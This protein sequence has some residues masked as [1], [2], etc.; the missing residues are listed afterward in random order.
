MIRV[1]VVDDSA[2]V[3]RTLTDILSSETGI[4]VVAT[5]PNASLALSRFEAL[6]PDV[7]T[8]DVEMPDSSGLDLLRDL[9]RK[10]QTV[11]VIMFSA[12][13]QKAAA[14]TLDALALGASDYVTKPSGLGSRA[15]VEAHIR[16]ALVPRIRALGTT[17][18]R[19]S[20][21]R[22]DPSL[23]PVAMAGAARRVS[24][25]AIGCSTG[26]PNALADVFKRLPA[27]LTVPIVIVQH[28]PP[29]FTRLL[30]ER[31]TASSPIAV[32]E[33]E[34]GDVLTPGRALIAPGDHHLRLVREGARI[35][36]ALD[37]GPPE[38]SCRPAVDVLFR[39][40][41]SVYRAQ[42]LA[43][44][45]TGMGQDGLKGCEVIREAG[46]QILAQD[47]KTS[48]VWGMPGFVARA[49]LADAVVPLEDVASQIVQRVLASDGSTRNE[50]ARHAR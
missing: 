1:L 37:Q 6:R 44:V 25:L 36:A 35:V 46:G 41:A 19:L 42:S 13:T 17:K 27:S 22:R 47:E 30:A 38:N 15:E 20:L 32:K 12:L 28:M 9:R 3:R 43:V 23:R 5:A 16:S 8:L 29:V 4:E 14:T 33:A 50:E 18:A 24:V 48:V 7:V 31:L 21:P 40:V 26:G 34:A 45:L 10:S 39:S 11:P 49:G 2:V